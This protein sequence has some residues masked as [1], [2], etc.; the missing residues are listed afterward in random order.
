MPTTPSGP[1]IRNGMRQPQ[2]TRSPSLR[3]YW[4]T[5]AMDAAPEYPARVPNSRK[6][7]KN[8]RFLSGAYSAMKVEAPPYSPPVEKP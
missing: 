8:P 4:R 3:V 6:L 1:P 5:A 7:P 2:E